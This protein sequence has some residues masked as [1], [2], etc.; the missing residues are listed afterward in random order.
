VVKVTLFLDKAFNPWRDRSTADNRD[1]GVAVAAI[2]LVRAG[3][4]AQQVA[5]VAGCQQT[6]LDGARMSF[7]RED[8]ENEHCTNPE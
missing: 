7:E 4:E 6:V 5:P 8:E 2:V 1:L 3:E